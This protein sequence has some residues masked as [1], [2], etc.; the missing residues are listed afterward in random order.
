MNISVIV[1]VYNAEKYLPAC[2]QSILGQTFQDFELILVDDGS[3]DQSRSLCDKYA[4]ASSRTKVIHQ[5]NLGQTKARLA[6]LFAARGEYVLF[7]D[8]DDFLEA[9]MLEIMAGEAVRYSADVVECG[10]YAGPSGHQVVAHSS[11]RTGFYT[12]KE[13]ETEIIPSML[14]H[15]TAP[16]RFGIAPNLWNKLFRRSL[17]LRFLPAVPSEIHNGEDGLLTYQCILAADSLVI[18]N[19]ALYHYCSHPESISRRIDESRLRENHQLFQC[20]SEIC[21]SDRVLR[22][23]LYPY[24]V[25]QTLQ[26][27]SSSLAEK[28]MGEVRRICMSIWEDR[29]SPEL[30]SIHKVRARDFSGRRNRLL[31]LWMKTW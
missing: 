8:S 5:D 22:R 17:A 26:Y 14:C 21:G 9:R 7:A 28:K 30:V 24:V 13:L 2:V 1:P 12:R 4:E 31:I 6:G 3:T 15:G 29:S 25:Y 19:D 27:V 20:Y 18:V 16:Y 10:Y 23:Q 11:Y